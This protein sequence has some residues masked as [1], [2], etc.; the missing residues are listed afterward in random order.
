[1]STET[2]TNSTSGFQ[3][4]TKTGGAKGKR[5]KKKGGAKQDIAKRKNEEL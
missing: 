2:R 5:I 4:S 3:L 1:M